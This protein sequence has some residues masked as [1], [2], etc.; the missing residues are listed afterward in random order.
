MT[1]VTFKYRKSLIVNF[2]LCILLKNRD[3]N[4]LK[5]IV[6]IFFK[7]KY[8]F[9]VQTYFPVEFLFSVNKK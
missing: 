5:F 4:M 8:Y 3:E 7:I 6:N 1:F 9:Q 2:Y